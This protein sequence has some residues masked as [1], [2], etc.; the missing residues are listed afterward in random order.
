MLRYS[1]QVLYLGMKWIKHPVLLNYYL[2]Y[3]CNAKCEF[4]DIWERPSPYADKN[5]VFNNLEQAKKLRVKVVDF[6]GGEPLL[7]Q[8]LPLFLQKAKE[9]GM[10][11]TV[12]T[13]T[14]LYPKY[15]EK[16][17]GKIDMLHFSLDSSIKEKHDASRGVKCFDSVMQS[18]EIALKLGQKPDIL[19]T[20]FEH[21]LC[22]IEQVYENITQPNDLILILNPVFEYNQVGEHLSYQ[23]LNTLSEWGR[24]KG[25]Y[26]NQAFITLRKN[27]GNHIDNPVCKAGSSTL[28]ISPSNELVLPCYHLGKKSFVIENNL[29]NLYHSKEVQEIVKMEGRLPECEGCTVNCYFQPSFAVSINKYFWQ[30]FP[31]TLKYTLEK[32]V[33]AGA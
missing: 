11:T 2:T 33:Y 18:I 31:S 27:G 22:E 20:V 24:K 14:L 29:Y 23:T 28:V 4:C 19:F 1:V 15:A 5:T 6:T 10:V 3:R 17:Q 21:N 8:E 13:N 16:L 9:L 26:L 32:W 30:A 25:V 12:T 7:H